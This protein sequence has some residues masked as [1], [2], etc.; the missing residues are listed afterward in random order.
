MSSSTCHLHIEE[1]ARTIS[2]LQLTD[3]HLFADENG[4][5]LGVKT[6]ASFR[7]VLQ[8]VL[9]QNMHYDFVIMSGDISQ[10]YSQTSY[11]RFAQM[12]SVLNAPVFFVP[13]N[14]D[15]GP[16]MYRCFDGYGIH[17]ERSLVCGNWLFVFLNSE[18]YGVPHGWTERNELYYLRQKAEEYPDKNVVAVVHHLPQY[19]GSRWLDTQTMHNQD[20]FNSFV[21][22]IRN[23]RLVLSGHVH[24]EFDSVF[25]SIRY[26]ASPST[27]IQFEPLSYDFALDSRGPG[28]RY[29]EFDHYGGID[30]RV[31]RLP[32][33]RFV[34]DRDVCGY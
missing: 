21:S 20:E 30:T 33:G 28:W 18:V 24:Q 5:L 12:V 1:E 26:I 31:Y 32:E 15:D 25:G 6:A 16:L 13:G 2:V 29:L 8:S 22:G 14:H 27:S 3:T 4:S 23:M 7:A 10:D 17:T 11:Q 9:N 19:V 34:P